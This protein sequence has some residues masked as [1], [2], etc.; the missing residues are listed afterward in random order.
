MKTMT[1]QKPWEEIMAHPDLWQAKYA[2]RK[3]DPDR[4]ID[5]PF[6]R[7]E[8]ES[9]GATFHLTSKPLRIDDSIMSTGEI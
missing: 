5:I 6:Q 7:N 1:A 8:L 9:P 3:D 2:R 4:Y